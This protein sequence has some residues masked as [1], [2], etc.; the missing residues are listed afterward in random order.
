MPNSVLWL[1]APPDL[2]NVL[3]GFKKKKKKADS[4]ILYFY[5]AGI[6]STISCSDLGVIFTYFM[7]AKQGTKWW[8]FFLLEEWNI[9]TKSMF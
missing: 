5:K 3:T 7:I 6:T 4:G 8:L 9:K 2:V 1:T